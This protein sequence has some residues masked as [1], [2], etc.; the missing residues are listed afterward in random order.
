[1]DDPVQRRELDEIVSWTKAEANRLSKQM[2][3]RMAWG[4]A[5]GNASIRYNVNKKQL[6]Q[7]MQRRGQAVRKKNAARRKIGAE[8]PKKR[9]PSM[10]VQ[11]GLGF[12]ENLD[13]ALGLQK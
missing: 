2:P 6:A 8:T 10:D 3:R 1:M 11:L 13:R 5:I 9:P 7:H 4:K 12:E